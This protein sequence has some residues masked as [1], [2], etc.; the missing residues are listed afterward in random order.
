MVQARA[1]ELADAIRTSPEYV[2]YRE[3]KER[4][5]ES[6]TAKALIKEYKKLQV[7]LQMNAMAGKGMAGEEMQR[8]SQIS[9]LLYGGTDTSR[10]LLAEMRLQKMMGDVFKLLSDAA[11]IHFDL[12][13]M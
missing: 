5:E 13:E 2:E 9:S 4:M 12:P 7:T 10:F 1:R 6:D 8:F 3:A 11:D